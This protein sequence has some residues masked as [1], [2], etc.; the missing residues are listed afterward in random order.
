VTTDWFDGRTDGQGHAEVVG[1]DAKGL[2]IVQ[3]ADRDLVH[4]NPAHRAGIDQ[5]T[6]L[7]TAPH[8]SAVLNQGRV[9]DAG[10]AGTLSPLSANDGD[11]VWL[12]TDDGTIWLYSATA[13]LREVAKVV[14]TSTQGPPGVAISGPCR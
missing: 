8:V 5:R 6:I 3:L 10:V 9:G 4:T 14:R 1:T 13:G 12:A 2:P 11:R 7:L